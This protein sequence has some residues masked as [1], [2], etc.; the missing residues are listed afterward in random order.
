MSLLRSPKSPDDHCDMG[1]HSFSWGLYV[2]E[3]AFPQVT[4]WSRAQALQ[5]WEALEYPFH[6][7]TPI[8]EWS[9]SSFS[10]TFMRIVSP[11]GNVLWTAMKKAEREENAICVRLYE[12]FGCPCDA[13]LMISPQL[14]IQKAIETNLLEHDTQV[15]H[16][17]N[18]DTN[19][20]WILSFSIQS[21]EI[22]TFVLFSEK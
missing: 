22:K 15:T 18:I 19:G 1:K 17:G 10:Q 12:A 9:F 6:V 16:T 4:V 21:F 7:L 11:Y 8:Q 13:Q 2:H 3:G 14:H 5:Q 20:E